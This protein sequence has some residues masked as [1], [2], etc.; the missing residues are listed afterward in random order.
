MRDA[1]EED[2]LARLQK[3]PPAAFVFTDK[4]PLMTWPDAWVDLQ[5]A[6][7]RTAAWVRANYKQTAVFDVQRVWLRR[8]RADGLAEAEPFPM[9]LTEAERR[10][11]EASP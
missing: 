6:A 7:P 2:M 8:D 1:H 10:A 11:A 3:D 5:K 9:D 4:S